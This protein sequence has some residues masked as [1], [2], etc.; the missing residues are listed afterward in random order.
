MPAPFVSTRFK[1]LQP[2]DMPR[3]AGLD[4]Q[5]KRIE[6]LPDPTEIGD[7]GEVAKVGEYVTITSKKTRIQRRIVYLIGK[8]VPYQDIR[9]DIL[10]KTGLSPVM[11]ARYFREVAEAAREANDS[12]EL[13]DLVIRDGLDKVRRLTSTM[14]NLAKRDLPDSTVDPATGEEVPLAADELAVLFKAQVAAAKEAR[15]GVETI[16]DIVGRRSKRWTPKQQVDVQPIIGGTDEQQE[17]V[18]RLLGQE[19]PATRQIVDTTAAEPVEK[20]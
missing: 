13:A 8:G 12:E 17:A 2:A 20:E 14:Y 4:V 1:R 9:R 15:Q 6:G 10:E 7:D 3:V 11:F 16:A 5:V 19:A 18:R